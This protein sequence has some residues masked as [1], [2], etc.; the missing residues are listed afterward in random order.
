MKS[1]TQGPL[2]FAM[3]TDFEYFRKRGY[4][5]VNALFLSLV[6]L[7]SLGKR[8]KSLILLNF[9]NLLKLKGG[10]QMIY[11]KGFRIMLTLTVV[12]IILFPKFQALAQEEYPNRPIEM[13]IPVVPGPNVDLGIRFFTNKWAEFL[14]QPVIAVNK[15]GASGVLAARYV[16]QAKPDGYKLFTGADGHFITARLLRTDAGYDLDSFRML[17]AYAKTYLF[18]FVKLDSRWKTLKDFFAEAKNN[19]GKLKYA[20]TGIGSTQ[21]VV[22]ELLA[23]VAGVK[24][25]LVPFKSS[26]ENLTALVGGNVDIASGF[27]LTGLGQSGMVKPLGV[28]SEERLPDCPD[29]PTLKEQGYPIEYPYT[30]NMVAAPSKTPEKIVTKFVEAHNKVLVKYAKEIK[31]KFPKMDL[32]PV[33][34]GGE[35]LTKELKE[36]EKL[37]KGFYSRTGIK[38]E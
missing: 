20:A 23:S 14:R 35:A 37:L 1:V 10:G 9:N 31:E 26:P 22:F 3:N 11:L 17:F 33:Y 18:F 19:P 29:V 15:P 5:N 8:G 4:T 24:L 28:S 2:D 38:I 30:Y 12:S 13:I 16:A 7:A 27:G 25:T 36:K 32:Y 34:V 6:V 21:H